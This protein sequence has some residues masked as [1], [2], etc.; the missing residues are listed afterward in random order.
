MGT[1]TIPWL[2]PQASMNFGTGRVI[3]T[4]TRCTPKSL[5]CDNC[6]AERDHDTKRIERLNGV[7]AHTAQYELPFKLKKG[8]KPSIMA[9]RIDDP[10]HVRKPCFWLVNSVGDLFHPGVPVD[11]IKALFAMMKKPKAQRHYFIFLTKYTERMLKVMK[12][13]GDL[14]ANCSPGVSVEDND[15]V[16]RIDHLRLFAQHTNVKSPLVVSFEPLIGSCERANLQDIG[17]IFIGGESG[18][19]RK[20]RPMND[21]WV[22]E[23]VALAHDRPEKIPVHFKQ[24]VLPT[25]YRDQHPL[26]DGVLIQ[27]FPAIRSCAECGGIVP[28]GHECPWFTQLTLFA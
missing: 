11:H 26:L 27:E 4:I 21:M 28:P 5:G 20:R 10:L 15:Y 9:D 23:L 13:L 8:E 2:N 12:E 3:N 22:R 16:T 6:W 18:D 7:H 1:T 24:R 14:P 25:G 19:T 17:W